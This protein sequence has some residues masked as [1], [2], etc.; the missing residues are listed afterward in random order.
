MP[1]DQPKHAERARA[2]HANPFVISAPDVPN[3][4][5]FPMLPSAATPNPGTM[6]PQVSGLL[7]HSERDHPD[8]ELTP[9]LARRTRE[10]PCCNTFG[11]AVALD[12]TLARCEHRGVK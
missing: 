7:P 12:G 5:D 9:D 11:L 1:P 2:P 3:H 8:L 4:E 10:C 6:N